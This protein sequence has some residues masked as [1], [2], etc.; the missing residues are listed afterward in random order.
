MKAKLVDNSYVGSSSIASTIE[1]YTKKHWW[2]S[3]VF[4]GSSINVRGALLLLSTEA[5]PLYNITMDKYM[6]KETYAK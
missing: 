5:S 6:L 4:R 2:N 3:W 1:L